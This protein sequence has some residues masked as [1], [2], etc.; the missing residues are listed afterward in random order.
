M[1]VTHISPPM[2]NIWLRMSPTFPN[3]PRLFPAFALPPR[4]QLHKFIRC[5]YILSSLRSVWQL[6]FDS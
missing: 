4:M 3:L 2:L 1:N 6:T 5:H